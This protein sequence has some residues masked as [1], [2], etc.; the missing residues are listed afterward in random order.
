M[1]Q[2]ER[3]LSR[4]LIEEEFRK[5]EEKLRIDKEKKK[6]PSEREVIDLQLKTLTDCKQLLNDIM[7]I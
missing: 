3:P 6:L 5:A 4:S 7:L 1:A 2:A